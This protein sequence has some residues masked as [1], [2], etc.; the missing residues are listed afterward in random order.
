[1][2]PAI[3]VI[4]AFTTCTKKW[5]EHNATTDAALENNLFEAVSK[6]ANL[7]KFTE[8]LVKSGY[9]KVIQSSK[10]YTV[11]A[12][13]DAAL[14][15]LS[16]AVIADSAQLRQFVG[17]HI[18]NQSILA[19]GVQRLRMLNGKYIAIG[20]TTFDSATIVT[21]N[22][23]ASNG[24]LHV[25]DKYVPRL[26]NTWEQV[27]KNTAD[28]PLMRNFLLSLNRVV[29]DPTKATQIG[30]DPN[31]GLPVYDTASGAVIRNAFL[32]TVMNV[33][34]EATEYTM[35][36][37]TDNAYTTEFNKLSPWFKTS[38]PDSTNRLTGY[39]L[40]KDLV[41]KGAY[42]AAQLPDTL[43]S[44]YGVKVPLNKSAITASYRTSNGVVHVMNQVNFALSNKFPPIII[45]GESP[46]SFAASRDGNTFYR[47]RTNPNNGQ[48]FRDILMQNYNFANYWIRYLV[49]NV[50]SMRYN[51]FWVAVNDVQ[52]TP[53]WAQRLGIDNFTTTLPAKTVA[54][55]DYS[56]VPLGQFTIANFKNVDLFVVGPTTASSTGGTNSITLDYIKLVPAF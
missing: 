1:M 49:R 8:L 56:E 42:T 35:I 13:T 27:L 50:P 14:Q 19:G 33:S 26:D 46:T 54:Y 5:E 18:S 29:F 6:T 23:Y 22:R 21:P 20:P 47:V 24:I 3:F 40:V 10:N 30:T 41:F 9:D 51:A 28:A 44:Q 31:T 12:P 32:D 55:Q 15:S 53:L 45:Q 34:D 36:L 2:L 39:W 17:N 11:W 4:A 16:P 7:G 38:S 25:I 43:I 48:Q 37:L 52:T